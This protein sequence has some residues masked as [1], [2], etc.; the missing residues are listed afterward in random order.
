MRQNLSEQAGD[1]ERAGFSG[2]RRRL[3]LDTLFQY[4]IHLEHR[5]NVSLRLLVQHENLPSIGRLHRAHR[6]Q[7]AYETLDFNS[8]VCFG[9]RA[10]VVLRDFT[11]CT[12]EVIIVAACA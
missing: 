6:I 1:D 5:A 10:R 7:V 2:N 12:S 11:S 4:V 3:T 9:V 8:I